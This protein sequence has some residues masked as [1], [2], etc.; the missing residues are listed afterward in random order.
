[1]K[2]NNYGEI[3]K[4]IREN[5]GYSQSEFAARIHVSQ[6]TLCRWEQGI[7][8]PRLSDLENIAKELGVSI[9][10]FFVDNPSS[11]PSVSEPPVSKTERKQKK[12]FSRAGIVAVAVT[13][14]VLI[15]VL[16]IK[17]TPKYR[18]IG[19]SE[20][21]DEDYGNTLLITVKPVFG[22]DDMKA[23]DFSDKL[24]AKYQKTE[25]EFDAIKII[26]V[27][28]SKEPGGQDEEALSTVYLS[29]QE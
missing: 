7:R 25:K 15:V 14:L 18:V 8:Q 16:T 12:Y 9:S 22:Y 28:R 11:E 4:T 2:E 26:V 5:G 3:V 13:V 21:Y 1:M 10:V 24:A 23:A 17:L 6:P 19:D 29:S 27:I 20:Y